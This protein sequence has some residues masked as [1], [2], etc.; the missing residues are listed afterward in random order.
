MQ[1]NLASGF[2]SYGAAD[3]CQTLPRN[4]RGKVRKTVLAEK[5][6]AQMADDK[7]DL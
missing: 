4:V 2:C 3:S 6:R 7:S 1:G 5:L